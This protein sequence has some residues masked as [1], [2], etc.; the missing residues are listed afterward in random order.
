MRLSEIDDV[1]KSALILKGVRYDFTD[2]INIGVSALE[3]VGNSTYRRNLLKDDVSIYLEDI[4]IFLNEN[5]P[6][7]DSDVIAAKYIYAKLQNIK[8]KL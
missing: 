6:N 5:F 4:E 2:R 8:N 7:N 3:V 1:D